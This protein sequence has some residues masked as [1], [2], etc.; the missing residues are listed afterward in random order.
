MQ[1]ED[2]CLLCTLIKHFVYK[3]RIKDSVATAWCSAWL[4]DECQRLCDVI[5]GVL[6]CPVCEVIQNKWAVDV[7]TY[8]L[9]LATHRRTRVTLM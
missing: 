4:V 1:G 5:E 6:C 9:R 3:W 7:L 2:L 8:Q